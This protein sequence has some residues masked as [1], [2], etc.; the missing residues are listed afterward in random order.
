MDVEGDSSKVV[1]STP[2]VGLLRKE[3]VRMTL[4]ICAS[5]KLSNH[6][7]RKYSG[8]FPD[9]RRCYGLCYLLRLLH[10]KT[11][12]NDPSA[13]IAGLCT[14]HSPIDIAPGSGFSFPRAKDYS[15]HEPSHGS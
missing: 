1:T 5:F 3:V 11:S 6:T 13:L 12:I 7:K 4:D 9:S 8:P 15:G 2:P 14:H 10:P